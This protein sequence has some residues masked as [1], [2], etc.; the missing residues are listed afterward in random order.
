MQPWL[1]F[2]R[3][4]LRAGRLPFWNP[5]QSS[6]TPYWSNGSSAPLFPLHLLFAALPERVGWL[7]LPWLRVLV[8]GLGAWRLARELGLSEHAAR[9]AAVAFPLAGMPVSFLLFP[10][11]SA[12]ALAPWV[13]WATERLAA[14]RGGIAGLA[15]ASGLQLLSGHPETCVHTALLTALYLAVR[16]AAPAVGALRAGLRFAAG[17]ALGGALAAVQLLPLAATLLAS[18]RWQWHPA[19]SYPPLGLLL[20]LPLRLVLPELF[21]NPARG[22]WW[23]PFYYPSTAVYAGALT[24]PLAV[25]GVA[26]L[27]RRGAAA[28]D[29]RRWALLAVTAF[30]FAAAYHLP[31][32]REAL[33]ALPVAGR[34]LHHR[35]LFGLDLGLALLAGYGLDR[36]TAGRGRGLA[37]G[38]AGVAAALAVAWGLFAADWRSHGLLP[39]ESW[40][41]AG[42]A[43]AALAAAAAVA[44]PRRWRPAVAAALPLVVAADLLAAHAGFNPGLAAGDLYP[45]TGAVR[46]LTG[47]DGRVAATGEVLRPNA[48]MV[49]R[50]R[51]VRGDDSVKLARYQ[52]A[53]TAAFGGGHPTYFTPVERWDAAA[54]DRLAVRWVMA[55]PGRPAPVA[56]WRLAYD[57]PDA[58]VWQRPG[59]ARWLT[60]TR[61]ADACRARAVDREPGRW[62]IDWRC[63][64]PGRLRVAEAWD[65]GWR[66]RSDGR[67]VAVEPD[68]A[69]LLEVA[70]G[71]GSGRLELAYRPVGWV[72]GALLSG[73]ALA[74]LLAAAWSARR[75]V[76]A[77]PA[78]PPPAAAAGC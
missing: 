21:G 38:A 6:G 71:P 13:L 73:A 9:L 23:G 3:H 57:G 30:S 41:T 14:G 66:G 35:L 39:L 62:S 74:T 72:P 54:L 70:L 65:A 50:L 17:W 1:L 56:G 49:Y 15:A 25:A 24:L 27:A 31:G 20:R 45:R 46:F 11:G 67:G 2:L 26:A 10:M 5:F 4:E 76:P 19:V 43:A 77:Q 53:W 42:V 55:P 7:L 75:R 18:S 28:G 47:R 22:T 63:A 37:V 78:A 29:R 32:V 33:A 64:G 68:A 12:V 8:G 59:A 52:A 69:A 58:R 36:W 61:G 48:A 44:L 16:G 40:W 60:W 34:A 51:D